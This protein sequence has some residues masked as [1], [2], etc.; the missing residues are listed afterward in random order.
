MEWTTGSIFISKNRKGREKNTLP[1]LRIYKV[2]KQQAFALVA[3]GMTTWEDIQSSIAYKPFIH[4]TVFFFFVLPK[5]LK[6]SC[7]SSANNHQIINYKNDADKNT[8]CSIY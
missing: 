2:C 5:P 8:E 7:L 3:V 6:A 4:H 1:S